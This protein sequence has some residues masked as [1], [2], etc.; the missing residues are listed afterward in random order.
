MRTIFI[1]DIHSE[2]TKF[3]KLLKRANYTE[4]DLLILG[5]DYFDRGAESA[6]MAKWLED[7]YEKEN[8]ILLRGNHDHALID[9]LKGKTDIDSY[10]GIMHMIKHN[11]L[12]KTLFDLVGLNI[13]LLKLKQHQNYSFNMKKLSEDI[14][15]RFPK[16][17]QAL[18]ST[19]FYYEDEKA[20]FTHA[21]LPEDYKTR[22][23]KAWE[24]TTWENSDFWAHSKKWKAYRKGNNINKP[25]YIGHWALSNFPEWDGETPIEINGIHFCDGA[26][27]WKYDGTYA[28]IE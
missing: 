5:G 11:G 8:I 17:L 6:K 23:D 16:L 28:I 7:N 9:L 22:S 25:I 1:T 3:E 26:M 27:G 10:L 15:Q 20:I 14:N 13:Y 18:E 2:F 24:R 21:K 12:D 19:K 4:E